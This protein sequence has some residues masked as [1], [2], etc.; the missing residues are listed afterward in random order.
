MITEN[1]VLRSDYKRDLKHLS[2]DTDKYV[3]LMLIDAAKQ[4]LKNNTNIIATSPDYNYEPF[5]M[6][7]DKE[8]KK[9]IKM[10]CFEK[11]IKIKDFWNEAAY[12]AINT[13]SEVD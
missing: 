1:I 6:K 11:S 12:V 2:I 13:E 9:E 3:S 8:L 10:F 5:T 4:I 7:I